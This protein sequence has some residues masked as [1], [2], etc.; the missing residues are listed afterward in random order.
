MSQGRGG[1]VKFAGQRP[2]VSAGST[3]ANTNALVLTEDDTFNG[4]ALPFYVTFN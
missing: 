4:A 2:I 3:P 1:R